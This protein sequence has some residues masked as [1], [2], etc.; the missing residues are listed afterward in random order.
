MPTKEIDP[1][2]NFDVVVHIHG[3]A[4]MMGS[5]KLYAGPDYIMDE[6]VIFVTMNYRLGILG[7]LST[8]DKVV[9]GNNG[10]KDQVLALEWIRDN[11]EAFGGN[12]E[13][14]TLTGLF[15]GGSSVHYHYLSPMSRGNQIQRVFLTFLL[16]PVVS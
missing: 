12:P 2:D 7:F 5:P 9:P 11:I 13:S 6:D 1:N 15:S 3:G 14:V 10:L 8:A 4:F 16:Y